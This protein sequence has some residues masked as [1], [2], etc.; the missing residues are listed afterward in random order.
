MV[1]TRS[2]ERGQM[3]RNLNLD[4][5]FSPYYFIYI[6]HEILRACAVDG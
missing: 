4:I 6:S 5:N 3:K 1:I 2:N